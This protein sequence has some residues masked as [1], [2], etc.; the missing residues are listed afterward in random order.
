MSGRSAQISDRLARPD[1]VRYPPVR[2]LVGI[3]L[4]GRRVAASVTLATDVVGFSSLLA[5]GEEGALERLEALRTQLV[6]PKITERGGRVVSAIGGRLLAE[7]GSPIEAVRCAVDIQRDMIDRN[8]G[9]AP[10]RRIVLRVG[11]NFGDAAA[12]RGDLVTR[13]VAA[14]PADRLA[15][16]IKPSAQ[17]YGDGRNITARLAALAD[18]GGICISGAVRDAIRDRLPYSFS[19]IGEHDLDIRGVP[20]HCYAMS[21]EAMAA[22]ARTVSQ[23]RRGSPSRHIWLRG[24]TVAASLSGIVGIGAVAA[25]TWLGANWSMSPATPGSHISAA[26]KPAI[27]DEQTQAPVSFNSAAVKEIQAPAAPE[28]PAGN[29]EAERSLPALSVLSASSEIGADVIRGKAAP[30]ALQM[31]PDSNTAVI[32]GIQASSASHNVPGSGATIV[33]GK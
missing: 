5:A 29:A 24:A 15:N 31:T 14:L 4:G 33:R 12:N 32:R 23:K 10:A 21:A 2:G 22:P 9:A 30:A 18:P 19:D 3:S 20:V 8:A 25:W 13:A 1:P 7:F 26:A 27:E 6:Y 28:P 17:I 16:L 11:I